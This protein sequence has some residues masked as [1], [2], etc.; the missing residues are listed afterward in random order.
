MIKKKVGTITLAV[1]LIAVG[2]L[3]IMQNFAGISVK[4]LYKYWPVLLIG[5]GLEMIAY[6]AF[7]NKTENNIRLGIDGGC[8]VFIIIMAL[9]A[10][11][12][13][14]FKTDLPFNFN[15]PKNA[16]INGIRYRDEVHYDYAKQNIGAGYAVKNVKVDNSYGDIEVIGTNDKT[17]KIEAKIN[18]RCNDKVK[19]LDYAKDAISIKEGETVEITPKAP[20]VG[21]SDYARAG[22]DFIIY[23][24]NTTD[25]NIIGS[26]GDIELKDIQGNAD[27]QGQNGAVSAASVGGSISIRNAFGS[28]EAQNIKGNADIK[29]QNG[30]ITAETIGG[31]ATLETHFGSINASDIAGD[32]VI[33]NNNGNIEAKAI[34]AGARIENSFGN[35]E[36]RADSLPNADIYAKTNFGNIDSV[37]ALKVTKSGQEVTAEGRLGT[38]QYKIEV[39][40]NNGNIRI[41]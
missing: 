11:G 24:P 4:D 37:N 5:V 30:N 9:I 38:G 7:Y 1:G 27:I 2:V 17:I 26:F 41:H 28:I 8:I 3:L 22:V 29:N 34:K 36:L 16:I 18:V 21:S 33:Q 39:T 15:F 31:S 32:T 6:M 19:A 14:F 35:I 12:M 10:N 13:T 25:V 40:T 23:V 20:P